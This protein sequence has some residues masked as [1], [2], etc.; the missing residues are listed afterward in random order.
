M[1][2]NLPTP[3]PTVVSAKSHRPNFIVTTFHFIWWILTLGGFI[4]GL[5]HRRHAKFQMEELTVYT[6]EQSFFVW[7][8]VFMGFVG[9]FWVRHWAGSAGFFGW[10]YCWTMLFCILAVVTNIDTIRL[11]IWAAVLGFF[12][13]GGK[14]LEE[15]KGLRILSPVFGHLQHLSPKLDTGFASFESWLLL[16]I[17]IYALF[18]SYANGRKTFSPNGIEEHYLGRGGD[19]VDRSGLHF[20][21]RYPDLLESLLSFGGGDVVAI[22]GTGKIQKSWHNILFLFFRWS[23]MQEILEQRAAVMDNAI[24]DEKPATAAVVEARKDADGK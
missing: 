9:S 10:V 7:P 14:Y 11:L 19:I 5:L 12:W 4:P 20:V 16:A 13:I 17:L 6:I 22:D 23:R 21:C 1:T 2:D 15:V 18:G 24:P 8:L 3:A